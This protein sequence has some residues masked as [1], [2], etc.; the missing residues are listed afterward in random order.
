MD[1]FWFANLL[2]GAI[3]VLCMYS[4]FMCFYT[5]YLYYQRTAIEMKNYLPFASDLMLHIYLAA[6]AAVLINI[7]CAI[8]MYNRFNLPITWRS[9]LLTVAFALFAVS[10]YRVSN[11][12]SKALYKRRKQIRDAEEAVKIAEGN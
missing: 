11:T 5:C 1:E 9:P 4:S 7:F 8:E 12:Q 2:R 10:Q 6:A 3:I